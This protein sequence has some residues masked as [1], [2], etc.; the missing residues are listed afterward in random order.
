MKRLAFFAFASFFVS[1]GMG[2][3]KALGEEACPLTVTDWEP[4]GYIE[5]ALPRISVAFKSTCGADIDRSSIEMRINDSTPVP[6]TLNGGGPE[7]EVSF[8]PNASFAQEADYTVAVRAQDVK[9]M[10]AEKKWTFYIPLIY[11]P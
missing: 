10:K 11:N 6:L 8:T 4:K 9:G 5:S 7:V 2:N 1:C 3:M